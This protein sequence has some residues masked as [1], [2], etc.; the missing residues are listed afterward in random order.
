MTAGQV[1]VSAR[2]LPAVRYERFVVS[3][4]SGRVL[5]KRSDIAQ[6]REI[7]A[8]RSGIDTS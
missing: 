6:M 4:D 7:A 3:K 8:T 1:N 2:Q 5:T